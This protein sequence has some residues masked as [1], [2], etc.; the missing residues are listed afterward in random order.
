MTGISKTFPG[1]RALDGVDFTLLPGEVHV[2]F[3]E[4]G[5]GKST[6]ISILSG[7][8]PQTTGSLK[9]S[10]LDV[11]LDSV[12]AAR[13]HGVAAVFQEFSLVPTMSVAENIYLGAEPRRG[14]FVDKRAMRRNAQKLFDDLGFAIDVRRPV[15]T[16]SRAQQQMTE[17]AKAIHFEARTL[18][19]DEP[20]A[21]L[22]ERETDALFRI[23]GDAKARGVGIVYISHRIQE[24]SRIADRITVL[25]DGRL[26]GTVQARDTSPKKLIEMMTGRAVGEIYPQIVRYHPAEVLLSVRGLHTPGVRGVDI[27][28]RRGEVLGVAGLVGSGKSRIWRAVMGLAATKSGSVRFKDKD[29]TNA[30]TRRMIHDGVFYLPPDRKSEGLMLS[31]TTRKNIDLGAISQPT[32]SGLAGTLSPARLRAISAGIADKVGL[33]GAHL[34]RAIS[35]LSGGN[36]QKAMFGKGFGRDYDI[37]ILDEPTVGV[38]LGT[39]ATL[40]KLIKELAESGKAVVLISSDLPE[41]LYLAHRVAVFSAGHIAKTF[42]DGEIGEEAVLASFFAHERT[43]A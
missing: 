7:V 10:G 21:S 41:V 20:T 43:A 22:T 26:I 40:Y 15:V 35:N 29:V 2:L 38:D 24:F 18:I 6:L 25:R 32:A 13:R 12:K 9:L 17:I 42:N 39:R 16:L 5:A 4:N 30:A 14:P 27:E 11:T 36:Q 1:V 3:G 8:Y 34:D 28:V 23:I 33:Q 37:Y 19:L 31:A